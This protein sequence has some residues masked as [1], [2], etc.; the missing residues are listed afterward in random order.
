MI[1]NV[2]L[3][4]F[5]VF[6]FIVTTMRAMVYDNRFMPLYARNYPR[7]ICR[8]SAFMVDAFLMTGKDAFGEE[9]AEPE[10]FEMFGLYDQGNVA[11]AMIK[12]GFPDPFDVPGLDPDKFL[13]K[14]IIWKMD[15]KLQSQGIAFQWDQYVGNYIWFGATWFF[16]H[17][18]SRNFFNL[19]PTT[20]AQLQISPEEELKLDQVRRTMNQQLGL[21]AGK[22]SGYGFSDIDFYLRVG[23][24]WEYPQKFRRIDAGARAGVLI[25]SGLVRDISNPASIPFGGN[26]FWG[27]YVAG[28]IEFEVKEDWN[29]GLLLRLNKRF[30]KTKLERIPIAFERPLFGAATGS[31]AIDPGVTF[32]FSPY[33]RL[34]GIRDGLGI[35]GRYTLAVHDHDHYTDKRANPN[36]PATLVSWIKPSDWSAEYI[37]VDAFYD[38]AKVKLPFSFAPVLSLRW[39]IPIRFIVAENAAKTNRLSL[40]VVFNY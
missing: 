8:P 32:I 13:D 25:P 20:I 26:G 37:T 31:L 40:G 39:D 11:D 3:F 15:G 18:S 9:D 38:F 21:A 33:F 16:M 14:K 1:F 6:C 27:F 22:W 23:N 29:F 7:T 2:R 12:L 19:T 5:V 34:E 30:A 10:L 35:Q 24:I 4:F 17:L 36:P 28:D